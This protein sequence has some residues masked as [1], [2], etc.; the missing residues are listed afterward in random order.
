MN[1]CALIICCTTCYTYGLFEIVLL[2]FTK[3]R[4]VIKPLIIKLNNGIGQG[5]N[6]GII[7]IP[8]KTES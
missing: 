4:K 5:R 6:K 8:G 7:K 2:F 3:G 1:F